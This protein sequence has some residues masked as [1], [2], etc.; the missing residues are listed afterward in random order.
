[1]CC[2]YSK[3]YV[4]T[5]TLLQGH[6]LYTHTPSYAIQQLPPCSVGAFAPL[7]LVK[8]WRHLHATTCHDSCVQCTLLIRLITPLAR[9]CTLLTCNGKK[10]N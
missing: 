7:L 8:I 10:L 3:F 1:M 6:I 9:R 2:L 4:H 5:Q